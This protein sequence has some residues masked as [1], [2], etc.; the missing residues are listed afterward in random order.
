MTGDHLAFFFCESDKH[1]SLTGPIILGS[2]LRQCLS[3]ETLSQKAEDQLRVL[4]EGTFPEV[5]DMLP[6]LQD[7]VVDAGK[8]TFVIDGI[9]ECSQP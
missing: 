3:A 4:F 9:D 8:T 5:D 6:I 2:L 7:I 1:V